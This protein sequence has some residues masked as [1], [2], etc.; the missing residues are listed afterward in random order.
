VETSYDK[1]DEEDNDSILDAVNRLDCF[2]PLKTAICI[3]RSMDSLHAKYFQKELGF[4][5]RISTVYNI[6]GYD[7]ISGFIGR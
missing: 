3:H 6:H 7:V 1:E 5:W 4:S 2:D